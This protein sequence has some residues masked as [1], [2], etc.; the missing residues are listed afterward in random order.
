VLEIVEAA[1]KGNSFTGWKVGTPA[2]QLL[3]ETI[4]SSPAHIVATVR[5]KAEY[6]LEKND[7]GK[8]E[9]KKLGMAPEQRAGLEYEFTVMADVD[10]DHAVVCTKTRCPAL[11]NR[12]FQATAVAEMATTFRDWLNSGEVLVSAAEADKERIR[13]LGAQLSLTEQKLLDGL[14]YYGNAK[15]W[16]T[17]TEDGARKVIA[18]LEAKLPT[19]A[20]EPETTLPTNADGSVDEAKVL[21][22]PAEAA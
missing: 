3:V 5:S 11:S 16:S 14:N 22:T 13:E 2:Q 10:L 18:A 8:M 20:A 15:T 6:A 9:P 1:G 12:V 7:K 4:T 21:D 19:P 17:L